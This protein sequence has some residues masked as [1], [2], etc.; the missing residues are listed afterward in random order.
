[1]NQTTYAENS[2]PKAAQ[3]VSEQ[4]ER[5]LGAEPNSSTIRTALLAAAGLSILASLSFQA[6]GRK[7]DA[8]FVGQWPATLVGIALWYQIV[9]MQQG[10]RA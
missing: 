6:A 7:D 10:Q 4:L 2:P 8:L 3:N 1:M 9:K 5:N